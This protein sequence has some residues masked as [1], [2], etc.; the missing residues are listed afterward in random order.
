[1]TSSMDP[2][3]IGDLIRTLPH[4]LLPPCKYECKGGAKYYGEIVDFK[5][6]GRGIMTYPDGD[7]Y[8][9]FFNAGVKEGQG[10]QKWLDGSFY[11]G[12]FKEGKRHGKGVH[13]WP[14]GEMTLRNEIMGS[15]LNMLRID[16][17]NFLKEK[18]LGSNGNGNRY[19]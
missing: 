11:Q 13:Q 2:G 19:D 1:M 12:P 17:A 6:Q 8:D 14:T 16:K 9:G 15:E 4:H 18:R 3:V 7:L 5:R 10:T